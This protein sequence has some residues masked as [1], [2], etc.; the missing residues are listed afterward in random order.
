MKIVEREMTVEE[1]PTI[2]GVANLERMTQK[3]YPKIIEKAVSMKRNTAPFPT[4]AWLNF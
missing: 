1:V 4:P 3:I 2:S